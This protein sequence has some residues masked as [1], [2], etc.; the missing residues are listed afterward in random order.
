MRL[1]RCARPLHVW[2]QA[3]QAPQSVKRQSSVGSQGTSAAQNCVSL[4]GPAT[5]APHSLAILATWRLRKV[6]PPP[7]DLEQGDQPSQSLHAPSSHVG[8][9]HGCVLHGCTSSLSCTLQSFPPCVGILA[10]CR[11]RVCWPPSHE[12]EQALQASQRPHW[13]SSLGHGAC[14]QAVSCVSS[15]LQPAPPGLLVCRT[16]RWRQR[17]PWLQEAEQLDHS[18]QSVTWQSWTLHCSLLQPTVWIRSPGQGSPPFTGK[19]MICRWRAVWPPPHCLS[20]ASHMVQSETTQSTL[21][22]SAHDTISSRS[23]WQSRPPPLA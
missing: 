10:M 13:Q 20:Q 8:T 6:V 14:M 3:L 12:A 15:R 7:Q 9:K 19:T 1:E 4:D 16:L 2:E 5:G 17:W 11:S 23:P 21:S 18:C 22:S